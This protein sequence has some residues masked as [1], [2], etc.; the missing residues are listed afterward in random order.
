VVA[1]AWSPA[2]DLLIVSSKSFERA[3]FEL[4]RRYKRLRH[5]L[6]FLLFILVIIH[7]YPNI[8]RDI[9]FSSCWSE[10][11]LFVGREGKKKTKKISGFLHLLSHTRVISL[12]GA[13]RGNFFISFIL[14]VSLKSLSHF[15]FLLLHTTVLY[16]FFFSFLSFRLVSS[17]SYEGG[18]FIP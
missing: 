8:L 6:D 2:W 13:L 10:K 11:G 7:S 12:T 17:F 4:L 14:L 18:L 16:S 15:L 3:I 9:S 5:P 1:F